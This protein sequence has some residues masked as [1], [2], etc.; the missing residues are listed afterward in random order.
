MSRKTVTELANEWQVSEY[1]VFWRAS[2]YY[3][4][5]LPDEKMVE[6]QYGLWMNDQINLPYYVR[7][8]IENWVFE[9]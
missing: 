2:E 5:Q 8:F 9:A 4:G 7:Y 1:D 6:T 3:Y